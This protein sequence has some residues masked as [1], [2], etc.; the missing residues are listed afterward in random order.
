MGAAAA[1]AAAAQCARACGRKPALH[2]TRDGLPMM[3]R[4]HSVGDL[5]AEMTTAMRWNRGTPSHSVDSPDHSRSQQ[6]RHSRE[7][8]NP[9]SLWV[10]GSLAQRKANGFP[11]SRE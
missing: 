9:N 5:S 8:G 3:A 7:S 4:R 2:E 10:A 1:A 11:L 6:R